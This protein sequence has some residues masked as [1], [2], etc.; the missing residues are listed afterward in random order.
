MLREGDK[1]DGDNE[2]NEDDGYDNISWMADTLP[3][4]SSKE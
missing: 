1:F 3:C 4:A 2:D